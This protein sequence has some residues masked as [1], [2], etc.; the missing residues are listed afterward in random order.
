[1]SQ[2]KKYMEIISEGRYGEDIRDILKQYPTKNKSKNKLPKVYEYIEL[3]DKNKDVQAERIQKSFPRMS[4]AA[5]LFQYKDK[6]FTIASKDLSWYIMAPK[7][8][9]ESNK[10]NENV[11]SSAK[12]A[13][14]GA[15][16]IINTKGKIIFNKRGPDLTS[17]DYVQAG[18]A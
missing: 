11:F 1:M 4:G 17:G 7:F 10:I 5:E 12:E 15:I 8:D 9:P 16:E 18:F 3:T 13:I 6:K 2:F 14:N